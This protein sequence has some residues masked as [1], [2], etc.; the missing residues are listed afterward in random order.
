MPEAR[1][2]DMENISQSFLPIIGATPRVLILGTLPSK[3]SLERQQY[4][5]H[6]QNKFWR[7]IY[8]LFEGDYQEDYSKKVVFAKEQHI[9]VWDVCFTAI[10]PGSLDVDI[11]EEQPNL[12]EELLE[13]HSS[14]TTIAFNGKKAEQLFF[15]YFKKKKQISYLTLL[16]TSP[17]NAA[18]SFEKKLE[19][20]CQIYL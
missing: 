8:A 13:Q 7:I 6:P 19:N 16:S 2:G 17:A 11:S 14:I 12:I 9:A 4:Y 3:V 5:G 20:W 1:H 15:K 10:R 18:Y